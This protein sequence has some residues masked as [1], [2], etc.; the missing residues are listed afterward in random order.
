MAIEIQQYKGIE[1][2]EAE[3]ITNN[4]ATVFKFEQ[5][6]ISPLTF[7]STPADRVEARKTKWS[8]TE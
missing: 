6:K 7:M 5:G 4:T 2:I 3:L 1:R 8:L